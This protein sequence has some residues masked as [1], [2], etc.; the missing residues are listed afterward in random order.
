M[1]SYAAH[2]LL[3]VIPFVALAASSIILL[4]KHRTLLT[5]LAA[6]GLGAAALS[7]ILSA[8][9]GF[10]SF[11]AHNPAASFQRFG[12]ALPVIYWGSVGGLLLGSMSLFAHTLV[13]ARDKV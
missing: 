8:L 11:T 6:L 10:Y 4:W 2:A 13:G 7:Q 12:W 3:I 9:V 5:V 1:V